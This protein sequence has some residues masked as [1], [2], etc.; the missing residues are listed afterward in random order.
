MYGSL[1]HRR[2]L[3]AGPRERGL[4]SRA[5]QQGPLNFKERN[6]FLPSNWS[7]RPFLAK[8]AHMQLLAN[9]SEEKCKS[10]RPKPSSFL[11]WVYSRAYG[12][13]YPLSVNP[14]L[15]YRSGS[16]R[17]LGSART[18]KGP[19]WGWP[20][21]QEA[22]GSIC[23]LDMGRGTPPEEGWGLWYLT[24]VPFHWPRPWGK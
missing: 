16:P 9:S 24:L 20:E 4:G 10:F 6:S 21:G 14:P 8:S 11:A 5:L 15:K 2:E 3:G 18:E 17:L 13:S 12:Y 19:K 7:F 1:R 22:G 23:T